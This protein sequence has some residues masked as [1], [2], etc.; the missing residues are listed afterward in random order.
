M[1][2]DELLGDG[3]AE[4]ET[5]VE[6]ARI[7][8]ALIADLRGLPPAEVP[9]ALCRTCLTLQQPVAAGPT[10]VRYPS[11]PAAGLNGPRVT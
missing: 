11:R 8:H 4:Q 5:D 3:D 7:A 9:D 1:A 6:H 10:A 2:G